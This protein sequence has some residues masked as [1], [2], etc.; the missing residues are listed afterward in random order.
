MIG[1]NITTPSPGGM[2]YSCQFYEIYDTTI[3]DEIRKKNHQFVYYVE[4][5]MIKSLEGVLQGFKDD[6]EKNLLEKA[7]KLIEDFCNSRKKERTGWFVC[8]DGHVI[9]P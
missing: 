8:F 4:N 3:L 9:G 6:N 2:P 1:I 5:G 7:I